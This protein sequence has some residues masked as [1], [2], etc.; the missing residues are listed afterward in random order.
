[1]KLRNKKIVFIS[2]FVV[3]FLIGAFA[4]NYYTNNR[5]T[6]PEKV[7]QEVSKFIEFKGEAMALK[8]NNPETINN[9]FL[10]NISEGDYIIEDFSKIMIYSRK[11]DKIVEIISKETIPLDLQQKVEK[12]I[13]TNNPDDYSILLIN[14]IEEI[15]ENFPD[16]YGIARKG[17][18]LIF[19][20]DR[21]LL[22]SYEYDTILQE[23]I[24][25]SEQMPNE[26][27]MLDENE[28]MMLDDESFL[29]ELPDEIET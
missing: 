6:E 1:M 14:S 13:G 16:L 12:L 28:Q 19:I 22:Y 15:K 4:G 10:V 29:E 25:Q 17:D 18:Y 7:L 24:K 27:M 20:E 23:L 2:I 21:L 3:A 11:L 26:Q 8:I 5:K 9:N